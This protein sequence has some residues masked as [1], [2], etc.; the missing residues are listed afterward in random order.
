M[1][2]TPLTCQRDKFII[3]KGVCYMNSSYIS[4]LLKSVEEAGIEG[5]QRR[6]QP[7]TIAPRDFFEPA[8]QV[9][10]LFARLVNADPEGVAL[11]PSV[12]YGVGIAALNLPLSPGQSIVILKEQFPLLSGRDLKKLPEQLR[13][14]LK[15][16]FRAILFVGDK[17][18]A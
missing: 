6:R 11:I 12:S 15:Y 4:P 7:W 8:E 1:E 5:L 14:P 13:N 3:P 9:R 17:T 18:K 16:Q 2:N 10:S